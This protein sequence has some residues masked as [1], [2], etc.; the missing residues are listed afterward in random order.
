MSETL[1]PYTPPGAS[2]PI[3]AVDTTAYD[4]DGQVISVT[5]GLDNT[6]KYGYDQLG[7]QVSETAPDNSVT[8]TAYDADG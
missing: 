8:S 7:D 6:T 4:G 3:T 1:P 2:S 5:D